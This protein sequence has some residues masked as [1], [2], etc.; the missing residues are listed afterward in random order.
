MATLGKFSRGFGVRWTLTGIVA[1]GFVGVLGGLVG[2]YSQGS[3]AVRPDRRQ[4]L[5][6]TALGAVPNQA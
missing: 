4:F 6:N 2:R 5:R 3:L 1:G